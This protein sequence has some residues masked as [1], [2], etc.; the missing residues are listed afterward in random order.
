MH[1]SDHR[2]DRD[3]DGVAARGRGALTR[4][5]L[6]VVD[7]DPDHAAIAL[8]VAARLRPGLRACAEHTVEDGR[9]AI[10]SAPP[11]ALVLVDRRLGGADGLE[12]VRE[13][14]RERPDLRLVLLSAVVTDDV[15]TDATRAGAFEA[16]EKPARLDGWMA[17][18]ERLLPGGEQPA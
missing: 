17:L 13:A 11:G 14:S 8:H 15:R 5:A 2:A 10:G 7:D 6:T 4:P 1:A 12:L 3:A 9:R 16:A 18:L